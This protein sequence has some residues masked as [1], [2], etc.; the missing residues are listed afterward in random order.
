MYLDP[1]SSLALYKVNLKFYFR[2]C[3]LVRENLLSWSDAGNRALNTCAADLETAA[4]RLLD[5][6]DWRSLALVG[7]DLYWQ[8]LQQQLGAVQ[9]L[10]ETSLANQ[11]ALAAALQE[12]VSGWQQQSGA[13]LKESAGAMPISTTLEDFLQDYLHLL[14]P[15]AGSAKGKGSRKLH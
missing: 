8:A 2:L 5:A 13:A 3:D 10:T 7:S 15:A 6:G 12:A 9:R 11:T 1:Q 14:V 4:T